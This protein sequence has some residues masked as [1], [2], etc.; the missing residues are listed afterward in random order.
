MLNDN[1]MSNYISHE[2]QPLTFNPEIIDVYLES[3]QESKHHYS[4]LLRDLM[5]FFFLIKVHSSPLGLFVQN[6]VHVRKLN[7]PCLGNMY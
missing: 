7:L 6:H 5:A 2:T 1:Q 3:S 4:S